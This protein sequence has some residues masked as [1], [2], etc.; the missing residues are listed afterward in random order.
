MTITKKAYQ[1]FKL[2]MLSL[3]LMFI[4]SAY[5]LTVH[6]DSAAG[7]IIDS[8]GRG[9][10]AGTSERYILHPNWLLLLFIDKRWGT[11]VWVSRSCLSI[12]WL[13]IA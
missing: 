12:T 8:L 1:S 3:L 5:P 13:C 6:A 10:T 7:A 4:F 11:S 2:A 9:S